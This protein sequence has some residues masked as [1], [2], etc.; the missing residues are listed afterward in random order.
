[1]SILV[2][3]QIMEMMMN[4]EENPENDPLEN[5]S[6]TSTYSRGM[7]GLLVSRLCQ[8]TAQQ[9]IRPSTKCHVFLSAVYRILS[10]FHSAEH[11]E[12]ARD[13]R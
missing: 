3:D 6:S 13:K 1:M 9:T 10:T 5:V 12:Q 4:G 7:V 8:Q 2:L 11:E